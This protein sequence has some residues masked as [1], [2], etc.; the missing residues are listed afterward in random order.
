MNDIGV[1]CEKQTYGRGVG[2]PMT[3]PAGKEEDALLCYDYCEDGYD[4]I[5][6]VCWGVCPSDTTACGALCLS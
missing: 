1:S 3:C 6:P 2:I 4:G 5:G